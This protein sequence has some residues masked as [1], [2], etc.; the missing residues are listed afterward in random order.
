MTGEAGVV[1]VDPGRDGSEAVPAVH[2]R[3]RAEF[4]RRIGIGELLTSHATR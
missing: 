1:V 2:D 3:I 4:F